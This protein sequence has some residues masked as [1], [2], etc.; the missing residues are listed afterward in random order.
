MDCKR[1]PSAVG[2]VSKRP[3]SVKSNEVLTVILIEWQLSGG[4]VLKDLDH[5]ALK[6]PRNRAKSAVLQIF[7]C[8]KY[9][10]MVH[11]RQADRQ[12]MDYIFDTQSI[13]KYY[14][15]TILTLNKLKRF[16][17]GSW[18]YNFHISS[19]KHVSGIS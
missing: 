19:L 12:H 17:T 11:T 18:L 1:L 7:R 4:W 13:F 14:H 16:E 9:R 10:K 2:S 5:C 8:V 15:F 6:L 3:L